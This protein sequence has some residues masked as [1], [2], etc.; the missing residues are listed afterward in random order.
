MKLIDGQKK[1]HQNLT[2]ANIQT[3][4]C[5]LIACHHFKFAPDFNDLEF[6]FSKQNNSFLKGSNLEVWFT[7][8]VVSSSSSRNNE[9]MNEMRKEGQKNQKKT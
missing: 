6:F 1:C 2:I 9:G 8:R 3:A 7:I 5:V 4:F